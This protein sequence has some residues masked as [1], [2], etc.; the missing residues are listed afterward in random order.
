[1]LTFPSPGILKR[2][3]PQVHQNMVQKFIVYFG[4]SHP[5]LCISAPHQEKLQSVGSVTDPAYPDQLSVIF[6]SA[7]DGRESM[8]DLTKTLADMSQRGKLSAKDVQTDLIDTEL[9]EGICPEPDLLIVFG[10]YVEL[11]GYPP[12]QLRLAE[13]FC[14][15]DSE[16]VGYQVFLKALR[17]YS[18]AEFRRGK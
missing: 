4:R 11:A 15:Q 13:I 9:S 17:N 7:Q 1:M 12:W 16:G 18:K 10:P 6:L 2:Y 5:G 3:L 14:L 8:V